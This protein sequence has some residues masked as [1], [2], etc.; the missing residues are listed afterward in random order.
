VAML[1][2]VALIVLGATLV[3]RTRIF[4]GRPIAIGLLFGLL[5]AAAPCCPIAEIGYY[6][7]PV[8]LREAPLLIAGFF[9]GPLAGFVAGG[10]ACI[11]A[12]VT[13]AVIP[14]VFMGACGVAG[15]AA[16]TLYGVAIGRWAFAGRRPPV[17]TAVIAAAYGTIVNLTVN[18]LLGLDRLTFTLEVVIAAFIPLA[19]G[20][21]LASGLVVLVGGVWHGW[22]RGFRSSLNLAFVFVG[23]AISATSVIVVL[24]A[25]D[26]GDAIVR[27]ALQDL[28]AEEENQARYMLHE[29]A[30]KIIDALR[31]LK[32]P[33]TRADLLHCAEVFGVDCITLA[34]TNGMVTVTTEP[35]VAIGQPLEREP[36]ELQAYLEMCDGGRPFVA[37]PFLPCDDGTDEYIKRFG[38]PMPGGGILRLGY[39][40]S[41]FQLVFPA[42]IKPSLDGRHIG[43]TGFYLV[44]NSEGRL[45]L[46]IPDRPE[47]AGLTF[48]EVGLD[49]RALSQPYEQVFLVRVMGTLCRCVTFE[50]FGGYRLY[51]TLPLAETQGPALVIS[52]LIALVLMIICIVFRI[53]FDRFQ[54]AQA[55][56]DALRAEEERRRDAEMALA[57]DIQLAELR[58]DGTEGPGYRLCTMMN[59]A[60]EVGGDFYDYFTLPDG[61]LV[62]VMADVSGKGIPAA[63]FMMKARMTIKSSVYSSATLAEAVAKANRRL[64]DHNPAEMFVTAWVGI[65]NRGEATLSF[66]SAGHNPPLVR[67][68]GGSVEWLEAPRAAALGVFDEVRYREARIEL[69]TG[70][71]LFLYTDGVNEAMNVGG[72]LFGN[73]RLFAVLAAE[74]PLVPA[75]RSAVERFVGEAEPADDMTMLEMTVESEDNK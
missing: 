71:R 35:S 55:K 66:V 26:E 50:P 2:Q 15:L 57:R 16:V 74:G 72:E 53:V 51:A 36:A 34:D 30:V 54:K 25:K 73:E 70:D 1:L 18:A 11:A 41:R 59:A 39:M 21:G 20:G 61:R 32:H 31:K 17:C 10:L 27:H 38:F 68:A 5:S 7:I 48:A 65:W 43:E 64:A 14:E 47:T 75:V 45:E 37:R 23:L 19:V 49:D 29:S 12:A 60:R 9:Y 40:W 56:I 22:W 52:T 13:A 3:E 24:N 46:P 6:G 8:P 44:F 33:P 67:R 63:F 42:Y 4:R 58:T 62:L 28:V 69:G